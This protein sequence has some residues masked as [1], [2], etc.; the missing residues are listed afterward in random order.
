MNCCKCNKEIRSN[1]KYAAVLY[2]YKLYQKTEEALKNIDIDVYDKALQITKYLCKDCF[3]Q[4]VDNPN[5]SKDGWSLPSYSLGV[6]AQSN[7]LMCYANKNREVKGKEVCIIC[8]R[9]SLNYKITA[10]YNNYGILD[11]MWL[12]D[13]CINDWKYHPKR[14]QFSRKKIFTWSSIF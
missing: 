1:K 6:H 14:L 9:S 3:N 2:S 4:S 12:C 11:W 13:S 10:F 8:S 5:I 7:A